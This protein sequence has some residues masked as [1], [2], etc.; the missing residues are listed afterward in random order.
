MQG[1]VVGGVV[2]GVLGALR[3]R[4]VANRRAKEI[5]A[6]IIHDEPEG[7]DVT[8]CLR[9]LIDDRVERRRVF[10]ARA[11]HRRERGLQ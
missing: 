11:E 9:D 8:A 1:G 5:A 10:D 2:G 4:D 7:D 3:R 6:R